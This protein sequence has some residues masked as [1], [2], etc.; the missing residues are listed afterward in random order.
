MNLFRQFFVFFFTHVSSVLFS[1][2]FVFVHDVSLS[3][4]FFISF[5][6]WPFIFLI[7]I[8]LNTISPSFVSQNIQLIPFWMHALPLHVLL[9]MDLFI[10][11]LFFSLRFFSFLT[12]LFPFS[13]SSL[14]ITSLKDKFMELLQSKKKTSLSISLCFF[15]HIYFVFACL[16]VFFEISFFPFYSHVFLNILLLSSRSWLFFPL[17]LP[18]LCVSFSWRLCL[19]WS[20]YFFF[21]SSPFTYSPFFTRSHVFWIV[22]VRTVSFLFEKTV[23]LVCLS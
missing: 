8:F 20:S 21:L 4:H 10:C 14:F 13:L 1:S 7:T 5:F 22:S 19:V 16:F 2:L 12:H 23:F 9:L 6:V 18:F 11:C 3:P 17:W 15:F